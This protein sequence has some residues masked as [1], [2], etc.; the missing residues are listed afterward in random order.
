[1]MKLSLLMAAISST[2]L[3]ACGGDSTGG[4]SGDGGNNTTISTGVF[5]DSAVGGIDYKTDTQEGTTNEKGEFKYV[6]GEDITF[7]IG[8]LVFPSATA[9]DK[10]TPLDLAGSTDIDDPKVLNIVRLL[11]SLDQDG[12]SDNGIFITE[13]AKSSATV[14]DFGQST[15]EF[16]IDAIGLVKN[17]GQDTPIDELVTIDYAQTHFQETINEITTENAVGMFNLTD[18]KQD[19]EGIINMYPDGTYLLVEYNKDNED[20]ADKGFE[21]GKLGLSNGK[22]NPVMILDRNG[23]DGLSDGTFTDV[24]IT[25]T[26]ISMTKTEQQPD[27]VYTIVTDRVIF[28]APIQGSWTSQYGEMSFNFLPNGDYYL[29]QVT[30][31]DE[32]EEDGGIDDG[33]IGIEVGTYTYENGLLDLSSPF[34]ETSA[35]ALLQDDDAQKSLIK[36]TASQVSADGNTLTLTVD[37]D[38]TLEVVTFTR[39]GSLSQNIVFD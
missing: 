3:I 21:F 33:D 36:F 18:G 38:G 11:L 6:A 4:G 22:F 29:V 26:Q 2:F 8:D 32:I 9:G 16:A 5:V 34:I 28:N 30:S 20:T 39:N 24:V 31:L 13:T 12:N 1:M 37:F 35:G 23:T 27:E 17:G 7:S 10:I 14:V 25:N 19:Y 15:K